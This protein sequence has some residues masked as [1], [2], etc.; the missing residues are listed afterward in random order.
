MEGGE[1]QVSLSIMSS[2]LGKVGSFGGI[3]VL[4][5]AGGGAEFRASNE[6][7]VEADSKGVIT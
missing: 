6:S 1:T 4:G 2:I 3:V 7:G 5:D